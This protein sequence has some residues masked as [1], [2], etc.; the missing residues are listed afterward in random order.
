[1]NSRA[2][3]VAAVIVAAALPRCSA[4]STT[5]SESETLDTSQPTLSATV[6]AATAAE[7]NALSYQAFALARQQLDR[8]LADPTWHADLESETLDHAGRDQTS[9]VALPPAI[10]I[11]VDD[12]VLD[13]TP[14]RADQLRPESHRRFSG[15][16]AWAERADAV[17]LP[18]VVEFLNYAREQGVRVFFV[19][20][21]DAFLEPETRTNLQ[22]V[23]IVL[24]DA[25]EGGAADSVLL[26]AERPVWLSRDKSPRRAWVAKTHRVLL[27]IGDDLNDFVA[28]GESLETRAALVQRHADRFGKCWLMLPNP[29]YGSWERAAYADGKS[30][31]AVEALLHR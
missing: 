21:R 9:V 17:A 22:R 24:S 5:P 7:R 18:G 4:R 8:A 31:A 16:R 13:T 6:W 14:Y 11:D 27:L 15:W 20:N 19:S 12:T 10:I 3:L 28:A 2:W 1:M 29:V 25:A 23:G 26:I 30:G